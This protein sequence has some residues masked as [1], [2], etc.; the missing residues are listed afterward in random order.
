ML[1]AQG[2][3]P[4]ALVAYR[5]SLALRKILAACDP[6]NNEWFGGIGCQVRHTPTRQKC[7]GGAQLSFWE[8]GARY[9]EHCHPVL[10]FI[11]SGSRP[12][13]SL[14]AGLSLRP[15]YRAVGW[16][17]GEILVRRAIAA[18][19]CALPLG[20]FNFA[21][22]YLVSARALEANKPN[23]TH[24]DEPV[25]LLYYQ[26]IELYLKAFL[27]AHGH[28]PIQLASRTFGHDFHKLAERAEELGL[29]LKARDKLA[30]RLVKATN[31]MESARYLQTETI[32]PQKTPLVRRWR[33]PQPNFVGAFLPA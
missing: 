32:R 1:V 5:K 28:T 27:R 33:K 25:N 13:F 23:A 19:R 30:L 20:Y 22:T 11:H 26:A 17:C 4:G 31:A 12:N 18:D 16:G 3:R 24:A 10:S 8:V 6:V 21:E 29:Q 14:S 2:D 9:V 15:A 7:R